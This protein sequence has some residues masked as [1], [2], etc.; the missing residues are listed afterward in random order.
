[1][2]ETKIEELNFEDAL[3]QLETIVRELEGGKIKLDD[4]VKAYE[5]ASKLKKICEEK[6]NNA[7]LKIEKIETDENG[8]LKTS[9][10]IGEE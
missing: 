3:Q 1:M 2:E 6:L 9:D 5:Q 8:E 10:F 4:A 7:R